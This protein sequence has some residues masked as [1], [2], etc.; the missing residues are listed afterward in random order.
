MSEN[1]YEGTGLLRSPMVKSEPKVLRVFF[2]A[3]K[4]YTNLPRKAYE[5]DS[6]YDCY[7]GVDITLEPGEVEMVPL[8][9]CMSLPKGFE[10][11][12]RP[13]SSMGKRGIIVP[14][15]PGTVDSNYRGEV[16]VLLMNL[17]KE[18]YTI[19]KG[20]RVCQLVVAKVVRTRWVYTDNL[21]ASERDTGGFGS[22]G[23]RDD[24][25]SVD[26]WQA[27]VPADIEDR[28]TELNNSGD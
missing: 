8:G 4:H 2:T 6:G 23:V 5:G 1:V 26:A 28:V 3:T 11:Q 21:P 7:S 22:T 10:A 9:F 16:C 18:P 19:T 17:G 25:S 15:S 20:D 12:I 27:G 24:G 14:N 13:R